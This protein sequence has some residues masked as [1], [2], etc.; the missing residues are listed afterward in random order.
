MLS[1]ASSIDVAPRQRREPPV[2]ATETFRKDLLVWAEPIIADYLGNAYVE[3]GI[4]AAHRTVLTTHHRRL[5][6]ALILTQHQMFEAARS[7]LLRGAGR[8]GL[9]PET[10]DDIDHEIL[11]ELMD[12]VLKRFR[13]SRD[14]AKGFGLV[15]LAVASDLGAGR[16]LSA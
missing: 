16:S 8:A 14:A 9:D 13:T 1:V 7:D 2:F 6:R 11:E 12:I 10:L 5:W 15:L 3:C 4:G